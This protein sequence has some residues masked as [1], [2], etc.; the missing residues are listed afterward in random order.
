MAQVDHVERHS[1]L[2]MALT[3]IASTSS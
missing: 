2:S 1:Q 3:M